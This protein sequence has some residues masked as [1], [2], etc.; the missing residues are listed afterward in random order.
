MNMNKKADYFAFG[1]TFLAVL[2]S[3]ILIF[4]PI[5]VAAPPE[6]KG[7]APQAGKVEAH[8]IRCSGMCIDKDGNPIVGTIRE[9]VDLYS[10]PSFR[11]G[12]CDDFGNPEKKCAA[13][14]REFLQC[15]PPERIMV[16]RVKCHTL[17]VEKEICDFLAI[18]PTPTNTPLPA[19]PTP[20]ST[21]VPT[22][23]PVPT[24]TVEPTL[25]EVP[26]ETPIPTDTPEPTATEV[27]T[28]TDMPT[29]TP[30]PTG[31]LF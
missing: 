4:A 20:T 5:R 22:E 14:L 26:T 19:T 17:F 15:N 30:M 27:P 29:S 7:P 10:D 31:T 6:D 12:G 28:P 11:C 23:T 8:A 9:S 24:D 13:M 21:A 1:I 16:T 18:T 2:A 25:T 3:F